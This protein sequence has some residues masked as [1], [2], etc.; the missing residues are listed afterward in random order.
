MQECHAAICDALGGD[1]TNSQETQ[2][3]KLRE[4]GGVIDQRHDRKYRG[5]FKLFDALIELTDKPETAASLLALR[6]RLQP[7]GLPQVNTSWIDESG[8]AATARGALDKD[9]RA[10]LKAITTV[11]GHTADDEVMAWIKAGESLG[12]VAAEKAAL[13]HKIAN[14]DTA[15]EP[16]AL[17]AARL[18]WIKIAR[19]L[20]SNLDLVKN[21]TTDDRATVLGLLYQ[22]VASAERRGPGGGKSAPVKP[23]QAPANG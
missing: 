15:T 1:D 7:L 11:D 4:E 6:A 17:H 19:A 20:E 12:P 22:A 2:L 14:P 13:E 10:M 18:G 5:T 9:A 21:R 8:N 23:P 3:A 16:A